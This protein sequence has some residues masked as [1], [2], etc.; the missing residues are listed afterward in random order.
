MIAQLLQD[1][2]LLQRGDTFTYLMPNGR[3]VT[4]NIGDPH[5][6]HAAAAGYIVRTRRYYSETRS[7]V[8][9]VYA[10]PR[11]ILHTPYKLLIAPAPTTEMAY[12]PVLGRF[13]TLTP[14]RKRKPAGE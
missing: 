12:A 11:D 2:A 10:L 3:G 14:P 1:Y 9:G 6:A 8:D 5:I 4:V 13:F 7:S